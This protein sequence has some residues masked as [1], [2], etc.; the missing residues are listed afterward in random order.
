M[1]EKTDKEN[2]EEKIFNAAKKVFVEKGSDGARMQEIADK[3]GINKSLLHYYYRSKDKLFAAVFEFFASKFFPNIF[4]VFNS[5][6]DIFMKIEKFIHAYIEMLRKNPFIPMFM[7]NEIRKG[8]ASFAIKVINKSGVEGKAFEQ[9][10][11]V[12]IEKGN[13]KAINPKHLI[14]NILS[15]VIFPF[16]SR[17]LAEVL[18]FESNTKAYDEFLEQRKEEVT[19]IIT[20]MLK[21]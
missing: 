16:I 2:T 17:P 15:L 3:A 21:P 11:N 13:I 4:E 6:D 1:T 18:I 7:L 8:N 10:I 20:E 19:S 5:D 9:M 12:E 14:I